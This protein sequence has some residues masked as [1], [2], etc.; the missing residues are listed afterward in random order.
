M[1]TTF[2]KPQ[3]GNSFTKTELESL[4]EQYDEAVYEYYQTDSTTM[5]DLQF[6]ELKDILE[7]NGYNLSTE[8][9]VEDV[10]IRQKLTTE[11]NMISLK[12]V[13]VFSEHFEKK[14]VDAVLAWLNQYQSL[15]V[16]D[17]VRVGWK[18]DG[19]ASSLRY[20]ENGNLYDVV[21]RGNFSIAKKMLDVAIKQHPTGLPNSEIR[22]EMI[23]RKSTFKEK[24][25][26]A[27]YANTCP[28]SS[29]PASK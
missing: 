11:N 24:Y 20:D 12:K 17:M 29:S 13:Q 10:N 22:C 25:M 16:K 6:D 4:K 3:N 21:T 14:H 9:D 26:D 15:T 23:M 19:C 5:S 2:W 8:D 27:G 1:E 18:L 28:I 7:A